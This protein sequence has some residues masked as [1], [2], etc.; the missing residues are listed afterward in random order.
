MFKLHA[1]GTSSRS[2]LLHSGK[3]GD[4]MKLSISYRHV[5][6]PEP[7]EK[8][9]NKHLAKIG[10]LLTVYSPDLVQ[11]RVHFE[12]HPHRTEFTCS[13]NLSLPTGTLH[14]SAAAAEAQTS[15]RD[16]FSELEAQI[17]KHQSLLRKD[18]EWKRK[19]VRVDKALA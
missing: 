12:K 2:V 6:F 3:S 5:E 13:V 16:A 14:A 1:H 8:A 17:K 15:A 7:V 9:V 11:L 4:P 18:F 10:K 19:R